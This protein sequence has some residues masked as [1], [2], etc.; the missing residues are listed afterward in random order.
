MNIIFTKKNGITIK[1]YYHKL[2]IPQ[3]IIIM[4]LFEIVY[5]FKVNNLKNHFLQNILIKKIIVLKKHSRL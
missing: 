3:L 4:S 1:Q 2:L 5:I